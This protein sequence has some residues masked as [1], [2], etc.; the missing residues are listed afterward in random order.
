MLRRR[1]PPL[2]STAGTAVSTFVIDHVSVVGCHH[3]ES[4]CIESGVEAARKRP[5]LRDPEAAIGEEA[6]GK[7]VVDLVDYDPDNASGWVRDGV[8]NGGDDCRST[9]GH[10]I[11]LME[12]R[13][14]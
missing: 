1:S 7:R 14:V 6:A 10:A 5:H 11:G 2:R 8:E 4:P 12:E 13:R 3:A 9:R